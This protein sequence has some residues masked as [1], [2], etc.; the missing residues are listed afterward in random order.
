M[1][2]VSASLDIH[3]NSPIAWTVSGWMEVYTGNYAKGK[4]LLARAQRL[5]PRDPRGWFTANGMA[6]ASIGQGQWDDGIAWARKARL[7]NPAHIGSQ[8]LLAASLAHSGRIEE[9]RQVVQNL[10]RSQP[11]GSIS[12]TGAGRMYMH[13]ALWRNFSQGLRLG[14]MP[15]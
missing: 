15:E 12:K 2:L 13:D 3:P 11:D 10:L 1:E 7:Q 9:A 4:E 8:R 14:G 5:S 6:M